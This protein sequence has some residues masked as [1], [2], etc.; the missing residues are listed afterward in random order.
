VAI[1]GG[2]AELQVAKAR[3]RVVP[4]AGGG[5]SLHFREQTFTV[6]STL[7]ALGATSGLTCQPEGTGTGRWTP[8]LR[9]PKGQALEVLGETT[10]FRLRRQIVLQGHRIAVADTIT[11]KTGE[12]LGVVAMNRVAVSGALADR[13]L[14]GLRYD[15][16]PRWGWSPENPTLF[17][18][19]KAAGLGVLAED[20][21]L[22]LQLTSL[23]D[24][25]SVRFGTEHL[26]LAPHGSYTLRWALYPTTTDYFD[27]INAVRRDW[28]V[29]FTVQGPFEFVDARDYQK[30]QDA[31]R[32]RAALRRKQV[33]LFGL[34]PWFE[35]YGAFI[36]RGEYQAIMQRAMRVIKSVAPQARCLALVETNLTPVRLPFFAGTLPADLPYGRPGGSYAFG[37]PP[38]VYGYP[39]PAAAARLIDA[40][41][42]RDSVNRDAKGAP[43]LDTWYADNYHGEAV[44]LM[45]YPRLGNYWHRQMMDKLR[46]L[47]DEVKLDGVY[48]DQFNFAS[49]YPARDRTYDQWDGRTVDIAPETGRVTRQFAHLAL[50]SAPARRQWV[51]FVLGRGKT[52]M[53]NSMPAVSELQSLPVMRFMETAGYDPMVE[54][55]PDAEVCATGLLGSPLGLG[56]AW[57]LDREG[58]SWAGKPKGG[59]FF[60]RTV[61]AQLRYGLLYYAYGASL[62]ASGE[63]A[64]EFGPLNHMFPFTPEEL[65]EGWIVGRERVLTCVSG[66]FPWRHRERPP[67]VRRF[68]R[69]GYEVP[70][71]ARIEP[72]RDGYRVHLA[73]A[74]W[75]EVAVME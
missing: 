50:V 60:V 52:A 16:L 15:S 7:A 35:Y 11:N 63:A 57:W 75:H 53:A 45:V 51:Q 69:R 20:N 18:T 28:Q 58:A 72:V 67:T 19:Q 71:D 39:A 8:R 43:L 47:L 68:D 4:G 37:K 65:H 17:L 61:I 27:F 2:L 59:E 32:L 14:S 74:D 34:L 70:A 31:A 42:W 12:V 40:S 10:V 46:F 3:V 36:S 23:A 9:R 66:I 41:P 48:F 33:R 64:G 21:A 5:F 6:E 25:S 26:G 22:R 54:E 24:R 1:P 38:G 44:H 13:R 49:G 73:L 62:P 55:P 30:P 29:N 56:Y